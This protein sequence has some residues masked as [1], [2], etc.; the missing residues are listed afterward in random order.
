[1]FPILA[2]IYSL[3]AKEVVGCSAPPRPVLIPQLNWPLQAAVNVACICDVR[4]LYP[5]GSA[6]VVHGRAI[7]RDCFAL[8]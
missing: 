3:S 5:H 7:S 4:K 2:V 6:T 8:C 1:M